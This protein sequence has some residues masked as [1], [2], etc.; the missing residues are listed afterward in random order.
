MCVVVWTNTD[1]SDILSLFICIAAIS[2]LSFYILMFRFISM[3][4]PCFCDKTHFSVVELDV[5][6]EHVQFW[7]KTVC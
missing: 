7:F 2:R 4:W 6:Y 5:V 1:V 3:L